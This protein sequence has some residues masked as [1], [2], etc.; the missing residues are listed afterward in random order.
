MDPPEQRSLRELA[1]ALRSHQVKASTLV[2]RALSSRRFGA[3]REVDEAR[4]VQQADAADA[5]LAEGSDCGPLQGIVVS[6]KDLYGVPGYRTYGGCPGPLPERFERPGPVVQKVLDQRAV[7]IGKTHTVQFAFGG[8]G[9]NPHHPTPIN[10]WD[11]VDHRAPGGSSS[12]AGVS[13]CE[14]SALLA[15]GTDTAGSVRIPASWT[16]NVGLKTT[17]GRWSTDGIVPLSSTLDTAGILARTMDDLTLAFRAIDPAG[18]PAMPALE[19]GDLRFGRC[20]TLLFDGCSPGV[21]EVFDGALG[22]LTRAGGQLRSLALPELEPTWQLFQRG[23][24]V[25]A[26]LHGFL[27]A[28]LPECLDTLDPN[29]GARLADA[30]QLSASELSDRRET[31]SGLAAAADLHLQEVDVLVCPTVANTPPRLAEVDS[32]AS[33]GPQNLLCLRNTSM[34]SYLGLCAVTM[35]IGCDA[36]GMPVG[37]QLIARGHHEPRLLAVAQCVEQVLGNSQE[38]LGVPPRCRP[39]FVAPNG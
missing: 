11:P 26:E 16:G 2:R 12:G 33:Y 4:A 19:L 5:A 10:P 27:S 18:P 22:E 37:L 28:E 3:Y 17:A 20:D 6:V 24:T 13:L 36:A 29:V 30:A 31:L 21:V 34:A 35:P 7:V 15:L 32:V 8:V 25:A 1:A 23:G 39:D 14:G 38:R 9:T